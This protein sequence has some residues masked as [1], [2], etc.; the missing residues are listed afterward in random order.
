MLTRRIAFIATTDP[1]NPVLTPSPPAYDVHVYQ[2]PSTPLSLPQL[3]SKSD[4]LTGWFAENAFY[5][6]DFAVSFMSDSYLA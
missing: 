5:Y 3:E 1:Y 6:D 2:T 4:D